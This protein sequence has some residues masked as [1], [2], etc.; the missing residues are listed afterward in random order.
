MEYKLIIHGC[1]VAYNGAKSAGIEHFKQLRFNIDD[2]FLNTP[3][4][5]KLLEVG[6]ASDEPD[7]YSMD[8]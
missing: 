2:Y 7:V 6:R 5:V 1:L 3:I 8:V 4:L